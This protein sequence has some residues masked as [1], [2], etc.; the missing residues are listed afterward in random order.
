MT[1]KAKY[2]NPINFPATPYWLSYTKDVVILED[3]IF[4]K[5]PSLANTRK[6]IQISWRKMGSLLKEPKDK[7][8]VASLM[9]NASQDWDKLLGA[10]SDIITEP[11]PCLL[12]CI[13]SILLSLQ[14][15]PCFSFPM[16]ESSHLWLPILSQLK[17]T[18]DIHRYLSKARVSRWT[19]LIVLS[20]KFTDIPSI[21]LLLA[22]TYSYG[23]T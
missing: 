23:N 19:N 6:I 15:I 18:A 14:T 1:A 16:A 11:P 21:H 10:H 5:S 22:R 7:S 17:R 8:S 12:F 2:N 20:L 4:M 9:K 13:C 3:S